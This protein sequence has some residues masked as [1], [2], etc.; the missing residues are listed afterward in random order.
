M[1]SKSE[2]ATIRR[3]NRLLPWDERVRKSRGERQKLE[4]GDFY[5][6]NVSLNL[7][8]MIDIDLEEIE[9]DLRQ[10]SGPWQK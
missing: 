1:L 10:E 7:P 6:R 8:A 3:I 5:I 2:S 9:R 4:V